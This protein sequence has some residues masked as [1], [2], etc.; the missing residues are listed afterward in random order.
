MGCKAGSHGLG[1]SWAP[2]PLCGGLLGTQG[3]V[4]SPGREGW[5][6]GSLGSSM[7]LPLA[8]W[9]PPQ[10]MGILWKSW[11]LQGGKGQRASRKPDLEAGSRRDSAP[12]RSSPR[13]WATSLSRCHPVGLQTSPWPMGGGHT[14]GTRASWGGAPG[15]HRGR[16]P[17]SQRAPVCP[18]GQPLPEGLWAGPCCRRRIV[19]LRICQLPTG[20]RPS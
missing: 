5:L 17:W 15:N 4:S 16:E 11:A 20:N 10:T 18:T 12:V 6:P 13:P 2:P 3:P 9:T 14:W 7:G 1:Q 8:P 19:G